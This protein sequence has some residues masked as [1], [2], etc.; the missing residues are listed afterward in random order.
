MSFT[1]IDGE[2][3]VQFYF[4]CTIGYNKENKNIPKS[5]QMGENSQTLQTQL[6]LPL[7]PGKAPHCLRNE[8]M[9]SEGPN[10]ETEKNRVVQECNALQ[11]S[12]RFLHF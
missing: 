8:S 11:E 6:H 3:Q 5:G 9:H 1:R 4:T 12:L 2:V 7:T 10:Q